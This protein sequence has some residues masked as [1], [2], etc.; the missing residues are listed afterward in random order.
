[1]GDAAY[2]DFINLY[3]IVTK[4]TERDITYQRIRFNMTLADP[5]NIY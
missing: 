3:T 4:T 1:M 5:C 2:T